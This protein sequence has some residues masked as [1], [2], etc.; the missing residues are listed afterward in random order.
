MKIV[1][2][3]D[4]VYKYAIGDPSA[5]GG[6]ERY[7][8]YL[9]CALANAGWSVTIGVQSALREG[10]ERVIEGVRFLG[11]GSQAH[12]LLTW[13][14]FLNRERPDWCFWQCAD[15]LWGPMAEIAR[16]L[17]V[18]TA[19]SSMHDI[20][21]QLRKSLTRRKKLWPL[22]AWGLQRSDIIFVQHAGQRNWLPA[23]WHHRAFLLP[24]IV[25]LPGTV[26]PHSERNG[27]VV[28]VAVIRPA[29]RPDRLIE[30]AR[31]LPMIHFV[32]CGS[33]TMRF[34]KA[35]EEIETILAQLR[36]LPNVDYR[37]HVAPDEALKHIGGASLLLSTSD[38]EGFPS[39]FLEAWASGTPVVSLQIDPDHKIRNCELGKVTDTVD[40]AVDAV[41][42]LMASAERR[43][44]MGIKARRHA[45][46][47]HSPVAAAR[48]FENAVARVCTHC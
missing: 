35:K 16:W 28:W 5:K 45:E 24:G 17:G 9:M 41:H 23:R 12:F 27:T 38:G 48:A 30:I 26:M 13:Y 6:A 7:G 10:E 21:V 4:V 40:G 42:S 18:R 3:N 22:Y 33:P 15:H 46:E 36:S 31:R 8:W 14:R 34:W 20:H 29:K 39:V 2:V 43:Q 47:L 19:F 1:Y 44:D 11:I 25:P 32:V 37:G